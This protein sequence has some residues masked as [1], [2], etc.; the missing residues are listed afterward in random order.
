VIDVVSAGQRL[1]YGSDTILH[2]IHA[3]HPDWLTVFDIEPE[4]TTSTRH[5]VLAD[6]RRRGR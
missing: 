5:R 2:P 4:P 6:W 1:L 3:E